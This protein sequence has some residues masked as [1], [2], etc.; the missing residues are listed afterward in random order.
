MIARAYDIIRKLVYHQKA[1]AVPAP[2]LIIC[3]R[4]PLPYAM[5]LAILIK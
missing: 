2:A 4:D 3:R 1:L 5:S